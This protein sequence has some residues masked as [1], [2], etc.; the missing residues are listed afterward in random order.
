MFSTLVKF[1]LFFSVRARAIP[2]LGENN[3]AI[4]REPIITAVLFVISPEQAAIAAVALI[5]K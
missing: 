4:S 5:I 3:V 2:A 1:L